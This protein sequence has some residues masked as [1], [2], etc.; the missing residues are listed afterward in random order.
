MQ[1]ALKQ[2]VVPSGEKL[3]MK[4]VSWQMYE[5]ILD[6]L[7]EHRT[8]R[9]NYSQGI[10]E[11]MSSLPEHEVSKVIIGN[12]VEIILEELDIEFWSLGST[13]FKRELM[14]AG[15]EADD[16]FYIENE[17]RVRGKDRIDLESDPPPDLAIEIALTS[18]TKL[19]NYEKLGVRE[20]WRFNGKKLEIN[21][22][23]DT[24]YIQSNS[25]F[26]FPNISVGEAIPR[27]LETSKTEGRNKTMKSFRA[28]IREQIQHLNRN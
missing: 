10:L 2:I 12:F 25:S 22:L 7:G 26:H 18:R 16:C 8:A 9:I 1:V 23:Q 13:T 11:I 19:D 5:Q 21:I 6:E 28:W 4:D 17:A 24:K 20:L 3:L 15:L 27:Y 14:N